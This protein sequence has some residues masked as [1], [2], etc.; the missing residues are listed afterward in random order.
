MWRLD[1]SVRMEYPPESEGWR[2]VLSMR[3]RYPS[4][5]VGHGWRLALPVRHGP[6]PEA[7]G[8]GGWIHL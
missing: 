2:L 3:L 4:E 7:G 1:P 8:C 5:A 6:H